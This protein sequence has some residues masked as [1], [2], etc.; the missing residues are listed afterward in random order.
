MRE[1]EQIDETAA[2]ARG[3]GRGRGGRGR[4]ARGRGAGK[5]QLLQ[6]DART[7]SPR[8]G[9]EAAGNLE[10]PVCA[11]PGRGRG[12]GRGRQ[13]RGRQGTEAST[14]EP[15]HA[16]LKVSPVKKKPRNSTPEMH[17]A[18]P[19]ASSEANPEEKTSRTPTKP[20]RRPRVSNGNGQATTGGTGETPAKPKG[21]KP[22]S[23]P[24][25]EE[26]ESGWMGVTDICSSKYSRP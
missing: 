23:A 17:D 12:R 10:Q 21:K 3:R 16:E 6:Q 5:E 1:E 11:A 18:E 9:S 26:Q 14:A 2:S 15:T 13:A 25:N 19:A 24:K 20:K 8:E 4:Q 7:E 22:R